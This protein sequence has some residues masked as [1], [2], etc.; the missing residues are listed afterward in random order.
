KFFFQF[1]NKTIFLKMTLMALGSV[2]VT[3]D[4]GL[5][6]GD[7]DWFHRK[8]QGYRREFPAEQLRQGRS[9]ISLQMG[10]NRGAS[11]SGMTGY[12]MHRQI[13]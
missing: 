10:S 4:D 13:M 11:Q 5:Y 12:G 8:A 3:N 9:L 7:P 2:A 6:K 1:N